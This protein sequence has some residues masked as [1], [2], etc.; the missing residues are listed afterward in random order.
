MA[1]QSLTYEE[2]K[3]I[4]DETLAF[5]DANRT[6]T[7]VC[8]RVMSKCNPPKLK[9]RFSTSVSVVDAGTIEMVLQLRVLHPD[10][11]IA[12]LVCGNATRP[13]GNYLEGALGQEENIC[14]QTQP[15]AML[16]LYSVPHC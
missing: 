10:D 4:Q 9:T 14:K 6:L 7:D 1:T 11:K 3:A 8:C 16:Q 2:R 5:L 12:F 15:A 13:G